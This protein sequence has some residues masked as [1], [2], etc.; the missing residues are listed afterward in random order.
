MINQRYLVPERSD[1]EVNSPSKFNGQDD[2]KETRISQSNS[3]L[4]ETLERN[5]MSGSGKKFSDE[6]IFKYCLGGLDERAN[7]LKDLALSA[8]D[9]DIAEFAQQV[10]LYSACSH[11]WSQI[12]IT[13]KLIRDGT[14][15]WNLMSQHN[16]HVPWENVGFEI[17]KQ[18]MEIAN[19]TRSLSD[20]D[21]SFLRRVS[22][23]Q[24][25]FSHENFEK[26][27]SWLYPVAFTLSRS[28]ITPLWGSTSPNWIEG[29]ITKEE[30]ERSLQG[31]RGLQQPGTFILRFPTSRS[32]PHP[33]AGNLV[34][35]YI[36]SDCTLHHRLISLDYIHRSARDKNAKSL[37]DLIL[38]EPELSRLG[39]VI[40]G[41]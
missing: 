14:R 16:E 20:Q 28:W 7:I 30:A 8:S 37:Q 2:L 12:A 39:R 13:K 19:T 38:N 25:Y 1:E 32:W 24:G 31:A 22:G 27:W 3:E 29:F 4:E 41:Q 9:Q 10:S 21:L 23:C 18:F 17:Q 33:D 36:G 6:C 40:R 26:M 34:V 15:V 5:G 35:T 11:H